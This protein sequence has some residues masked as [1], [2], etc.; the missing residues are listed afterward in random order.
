MYK[1]VLIGDTNTGK[2]SLLLRFIDN[3]FCENY[4]STIGVDFKIKNLL[5]DKKTLI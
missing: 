3:F 4:E 2:T 5:M 1:I